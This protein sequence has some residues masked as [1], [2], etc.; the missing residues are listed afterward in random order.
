MIERLLNLSRFAGTEEIVWSSEDLTGYFNCEAYA[1]AQG[2]RVA[3][4]YD[5]AYFDKYRDMAESPMATALNDFRASIV[6][7]EL[8]RR[9]TPDGRRSLID[10]GIGDGAFLRRMDSHKDKL[11]TFGNDINPAG[12]AWLIERASYGGIDEPDTW[13]IATFWDA[14]EH[15]PDPRVPLRSVRH[16][17]FVSIPTFRDVEE[18]KASKHFRPLEHFWYWSIAGFT[19]FAD[20]EGFDT[21]RIETTETDLGREGITTFVIRRRR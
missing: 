6:L 4:V 16:L 8:G 7:E 9:F 13:D 2:I 19:L 5:D 10:V 1:A 17:A 12:I 20:A 3:D 11:S 21:T 15:F 18:A 14:L